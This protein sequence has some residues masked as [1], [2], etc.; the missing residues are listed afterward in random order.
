MKK[1]KSSM[2]RLTEHCIFRNGI[3]H[4]VKNL[5]VHS[6]DRCKKNKNRTKHQNNTHTHTNLS[7]YEVLDYLPYKFTRFAKANILFWVVLTEGSVQ[8]VYPLLC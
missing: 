4:N 6:N 5:N 1:K 3:L 8:C 2:A 7:I